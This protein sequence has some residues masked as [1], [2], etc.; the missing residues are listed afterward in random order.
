MET[1]TLEEKKKKKKYRPTEIKSSSSPARTTILL[2]YGDPIQLGPT[3]FS[4]HHPSTSNRKHLI[5]L[6]HEKQ[7]ILDD[8]YDD[9]I[10]EM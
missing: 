10:N 3:E 9:L 7:G 2:L 1:S 8:F 4:R 5:L 6:N